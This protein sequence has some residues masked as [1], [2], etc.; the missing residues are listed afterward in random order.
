MLVFPLQVEPYLTLTLSDQ[1]GSL[2]GSIPWHVPHDKLIVAVVPT[3]ATSEKRICTVADAICD[4]TRTRG[5]TEIRLTDHALAA[6]V[7]ARIFKVSKE[8][9]LWFKH[10][11]N[12][13]VI[14]CY[15]P[16]LYNPMNVHWCIPAAGDAGWIAIGTILQIHRPGRPEDQRVQAP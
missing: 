6:K 7:K 4:V 15:N 3:A 8:W 1:H 14:T 16:I 12:N 10:A 13:I 2:T 11:S 5:I 9:F